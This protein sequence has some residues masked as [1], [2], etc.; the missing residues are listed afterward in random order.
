MAG[1]K[2]ENFQRERIELKAPSEWI[3]KATQYAEELGGLSLSAFIRL[4][5][6]EKMQRMDTERPT[7]RKKS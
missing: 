4:C 1:R 5:V 2:K 7:T 3:L 6:N